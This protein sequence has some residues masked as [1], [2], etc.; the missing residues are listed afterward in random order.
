MMRSARLWRSMGG[1]PRASSGA[2]T[3]SMTVSHGK[4][5]KLWKPMGRIGG[6]PRTGCDHMDTTDIGVGVKFFK[7]VG[8]DDWGNCSVGGAHKPGYYPST[9]RP[10]HEM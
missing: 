10:P 9:S 7:L 6:A 1:M 3:F 8:L 4:R 5:A 2:S